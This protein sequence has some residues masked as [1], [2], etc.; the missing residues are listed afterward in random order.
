MGR[1]ILEN[2]ILLVSIYLS[3]NTFLIIKVW[4]SFG[5][6]AKEKGILELMKHFFLFIPECIY[7]LIILFICILE[8]EK[9]IGGKEWQKRKSKQAA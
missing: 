4:G 6:C 7:L 9:C 3:V 8:D 2:W 5:A 1:W